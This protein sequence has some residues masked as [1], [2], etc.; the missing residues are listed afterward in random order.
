MLA[1][2]IIISIASFIIGIPTI[3]FGCDTYYNDCYYYT[4]TYQ[5]VIGVET[6]KKSELVCKY[7]S[8]NGVC[9]SV[10]VK[11]YWINNITFETCV[12]NDTTQYPTKEAAV[13]FQNEKYILTS[14]VS[15][16]IIKENP[17]ICVQVPPL[18]KNLGIVG[19]VFLLFGFLVWVG[20]GLRY[21]SCGVKKVEPIAV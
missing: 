2:Y 6:Q 12:M 16:F 8:G 9:E 1:P 4:P 14:W 10:T 13:S 20:Y 21:Y 3:I 5:K 11:D 17:A 18:Y 15:I 19:I 7:Y